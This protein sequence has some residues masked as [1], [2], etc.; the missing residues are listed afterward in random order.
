MGQKKSLKASLTRISRSKIKTDKPVYQM[1]RG[2]ESKIEYHPFLEDW[3]N[4]YQSLL[5]T[6]LNDRQKG[7]SETE[8]EKNY[9]K[10][11]NIQWAWADSLA[12]NASS[13]YDQLT[14]AKIN[15]IE[16]ISTDI[17]TGLVKSQETLEK[18]E[19]SFNN[20][21]RKTTRNFTKKLLG[22]KSKL[23]RLQRKKKQLKQLKQS[24]RLHICWGSKKL[25]NAQY[26]LEENG[27]SSHDEWLEDWRKKR[28][29]NF[30]SV[31]K[32]SVD[33]NNPVTKIHHSSEDIFTVTITIPRCYQD[34][35]GQSLTLKFEVTQARKHDL[36]YALE[37]NKPVTVQIFRR[38]HKDDQWYI[39]LST[40]IQ[41]V[42]Y[43]SSLKN[44]CLGIDLNANS[45][46]L[47]YIKRDGNLHQIQGQK[48]VFSW[49]IPTGT[50]GQVEAKLRDITAEIVR[51]AQSFECP[52]ACEDLD[53]SK[54]KASLRH[55]SK[56]YSRM[57]SGF[58]YDKF[59]SFLVARAE[60]YGIEV[61]FKNPFATSVIGMIKYMPKYGLNSA[62]AAAMVI[63]RRA[64]GFSER[65]PS[66]YLSLICPES[67]LGWFRAYMGSMGK[68]L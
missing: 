64:L 41:A 2:I 20:P 63:A 40:Y 3:G 52:V 6:A 17:Q 32:G 35:Y 60:K 61:I 57:L 67:R 10:R 25:F 24:K 54:K 21:T 46:D 13:V 44:G 27:Y 38:E 65:I 49:E 37:A 12:T 15:Q 55:Q 18:L 7:L 19:T 62:S 4:S 56:K 30:Y 51:I 31:G 23:Q 5:R 9:Q 50:T 1:L 42:P 29:G 48:T 28:G 66:S 11:F 59:R 53:F 43:I 68:N 22:L 14:T 47:V 16:L 58:V 36:L 26:H 45:I 33:G 34:T 8:I 39:H